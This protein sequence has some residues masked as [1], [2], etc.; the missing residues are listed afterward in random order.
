[1]FHNRKLNSCINKSHERVLRL[2]YGDDH[3]T[4]GEP[5]GKDDS[6]TIHFRNLHSLAIE[7]YKVKRDIVP[8]IMKDMSQLK[9][10]NY[11]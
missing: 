10:P 6:I 9:E 8:Q 4:F 7:I 1:M 11:N 3:S 2:T 5:L